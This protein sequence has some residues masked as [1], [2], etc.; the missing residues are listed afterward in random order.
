M[1]SDIEACRMIG[2]FALQSLLYEVSATPKPGLVDRANQGAHKDMD[3][4]SF[5][6]S[7]AALAPYF[8]QCALKGVEYHDQ[9]IQGLF[10]LLR[11]IGKDAEQAMFSATNGVNTHKGLIFSLG[12]ISAAASSCW[13]ANDYTKL[14]VED[15]FLKVSQM[16]QGLCLQELT[17]M[18]KKEVLTHGERIFKKYG[19]KGIRGEVEA[20]FPTVRTISLPILKKLESEKKHSLNDISVQT[21]LYLIE[22]NDDTNILARHDMNTLNYVKKYA[23]EALKAGGILN[24][25]GKEIIF[26]MDREFILKNISPGG[27]ADLLAVTIMF[28]LLSK[29][30]INA[31]N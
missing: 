7:G 18:E 11:P 20:G 5:M 25:A 16:T 23:N 26:K 12:I 4:F 1:Q 29:V 3:F 13:K 2:Q 28:H 24:D 17:S 22:V 15:V 9:D 8:V 21:L 30:W 6:A 14:N 27:S 31:N 10:K 19:T